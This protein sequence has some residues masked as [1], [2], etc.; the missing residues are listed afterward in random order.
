LIFQG[1]CKF[2]YDSAPSGTYGTMAYLVRAMAKTLEKI[3]KEGDIECLS[4]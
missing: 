1:I 2:F 3:P 4:M